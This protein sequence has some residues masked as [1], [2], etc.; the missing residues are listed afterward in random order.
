M[1]SNVVPIFQPHL[2]LRINAV[3]EGE[4]HALMGGFADTHYEQTALYGHGKSAEQQHLVVMQHGDHAVAGARVGLYSFPVINRGLA[5][6]RFGPF[7]RRDDVFDA[8]NYRTAI[9]A[10]VQ[11][12][13]DRRRFYLV[14]RPRAHPDFHAQET[15]ILSELGFRARESTALDRYFVDASLSEEEQR[16]SLSS[17]WRRNLKTAQKG[18]LEI[19]F[20]ASA[21][22]IAA[23]QHVYTEMVARKRLN[24][25]GLDHVAL[26]PELARL[27][28][29]MRLQLALARKDGVVIAGLAFSVT[30]DVA[31]YVFGATS[32]AGVKALAGY[33]L[34][35][36]TIR[37]LREHGGARWYELG[38]QGDPGIQ[39][40]KKGLAGRKGRLLPVREF[41]HCTDASAELA[42]KALFGLR[43][44]RDSIQRWQ[45]GLRR[46]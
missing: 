28:E 19:S 8:E 7:W 30:G 32:D 27:P 38:G 6:L 12:Y 46:K 39:Q 36:E 26:M 43:D 3:T 10:L 15:A 17:Q 24:Y 21:E 20:G 5:L 13:C 40:F 33:A 41:H 9:E 2:S 42:V 37:W 16:N 23:F 4:W 25:P 18:G 22:D 1:S 29:S 34:Q 45:R 11:E 35:W 44:V 14:I 31:Y